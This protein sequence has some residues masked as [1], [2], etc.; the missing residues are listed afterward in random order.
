MILISKIVF[1]LRSSHSRKNSTPFLYPLHYCTPPLP[2]RHPSN[3]GTPSLCM[4]E[5][6]AHIYITSTITIII[7]IIIKMTSAEKTVLCALHVHLSSPRKA[8]PRRTNSGQREFRSSMELIWRH[9][10]ILLELDT[11]SDT[12]LVVVTCRAS[13]ADRHKQRHV[14]LFVDSL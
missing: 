3:G 13:V 2:F 10:F 6:L 11:Y 1:E 9:M 7:I 12:I 8:S 5:S 14:Y 4:V